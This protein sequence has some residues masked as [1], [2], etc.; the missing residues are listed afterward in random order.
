MSSLERSDGDGQWSTHTCLALPHRF[1]QK[2]TIVVPQPLPK[3]LWATVMGRHGRSKLAAAYGVL[4][5]EESCGH[6]G[7]PFP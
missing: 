1:R 7:V 6:L 3:V 4:G 5:W 2:P